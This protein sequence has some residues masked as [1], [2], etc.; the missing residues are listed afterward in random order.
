MFI[1]FGSIERTTHECIRNWA[2]EQ[3]HKHFAKTPLA[4]RIELARDLAQSQDVSQT[5]KDAFCQSLIRAKNLTK[6]RNLVAHNPLCLILLQESL[7][8]SLLEAICHV[9]EDNKYLTFDELSEILATVED[10]AE[11]LLDH[12]IA[13]RLNKL[14]FEHLKT[15]PGLNAYATNNR[16]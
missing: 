7:S 9:T 1:A 3:I 8:D 6:Y 14:D 13:F 4:A 11:K 12:Y 10:C 16:D 15:F 5:T 2:G